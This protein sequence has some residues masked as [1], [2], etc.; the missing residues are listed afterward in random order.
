VATDYRL[1]SAVQDLYDLYQRLSPA[2]PYRLALFHDQESGGA[3]EFTALPHNAAQ[4]MQAA[5]PALDLRIRAV[6]CLLANHLAP[7]TGPLS[8]DLLRQVFRL[9]AVVNPGVEPPGYFD[10]LLG[11]LKRQ[12]PWA[13]LDAAAL[14]QQTALAYRR[15]GEVLALYLDVL[16]DARGDSAGA[17]AQRISALRAELLSSP[18]D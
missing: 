12:A 3:D 10:Y 6:S 18:E 5:A 16:C 8:E 7:A 4:L 11:E 1:L 13:A 9:W 17:N 14:A 2:G 15:F